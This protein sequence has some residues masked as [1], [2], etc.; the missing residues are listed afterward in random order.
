MGFFSRK[1]PPPKWED[2]RAY[3]VGENRLVEKARMQSSPIAIAGAFGVAPTKIDP[4]EVALGY[5][6]MALSPALSTFDQ[7]TANDL[8]YGMKDGI[9]TWLWNMGQ[10]NP[11]PAD[12]YRARMKEYSEAWQNAPTPKGSL[13]EVTV[14]FCRNSTGSSPASRDIHTTVEHSLLA[15]SRWVSEHLEKSLIE[16]GASWHNSYE[17][18]NMTPQQCWEAKGN[19]DF[20][21]CWHCGDGGWMTND[22]GVSLTPVYTGDSGHKSWCCF[23]EAAP[24]SW[25]P[26]Y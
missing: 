17:W 12:L 19:R 7:I 10:E 16:P 14:R 22:G 3:K 26:T 13:E 21:L 15:F 11:H 18:L 5:L 4:G 24:A 6:F 8:V 25:L 1:P 9:G 20:W 23:G 2:I